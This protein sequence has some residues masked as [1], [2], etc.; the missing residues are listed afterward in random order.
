MNIWEAWQRLPFFVFLVG[1]DMA[2]RLRE[3]SAV[4]ACAGRRMWRD[5]DGG[6]DGS[7]LKINAFSLGT[8]D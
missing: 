1:V 7:V 6:W 8:S 3:R 4:L 5:S 2:F